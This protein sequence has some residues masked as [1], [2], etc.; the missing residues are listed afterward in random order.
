MTSNAKTTVRSPGR[1]R[2]LRADRAI[3][4]AAL[5]SFIE[6]GYEGMTIE[7]VAQRAGVAKTT[8][9]RRWSSKKELVVAA[10]D[11]LFE[12]F[13]TL[14]TGDVRADLIS[15]VQKAHRSIA[16]TKAGDALPRM[17]GELA[18]GTP[19]GR[20]YH[21]SVMKPRRRALVETLEAA[22]KRGELRA[23]LDVDLAIA[24]IIG[25]MMF[26]RVTRT[27]SGRGDDLPDRLVAQMIEGIRA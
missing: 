24:A 26:L 23:D 5:D 2:D 27:L 1:P 21:D 17:L 13:P 22:K 14:E 9:Y 3:L 15:L 8:I 16:D 4:D 6:D 19:L 20:A 12:D 25:S 18:F 11:M 7:N 10:I